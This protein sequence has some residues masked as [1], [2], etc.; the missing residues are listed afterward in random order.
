MRLPRLTSSPI[1]RFPVFAAL[2][3]LPFFF[4]APPAAAGGQATQMRLPS[5]GGIAELSSSGPQSRHGD[6]FTADGDVDLRYQ[7]LRIQADHMEYNA[8]TADALARGHVQFDFNN[9]HLEADEARYNVHSKR[10]SFSKVRGTVRIDR[11]PNTN[12]LITDNPLYFEAAQVERLDDRTYV[13][14]KVWLTVCV[15]DRPKWKFYAPSANRDSC[16]RTSATRRARDTSWGIR[17]TGRR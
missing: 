4:F 1:A 10:G 11:R 16:C 17:F 15:P 6:V 7:D 12:V 14:H 13:I 8:A 9:Q 3:A 2:L 5:K